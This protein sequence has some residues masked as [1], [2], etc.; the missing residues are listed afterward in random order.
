M[1]CEITKEAI[2]ELLLDH[3]KKI[4]QNTIAACLDTNNGVDYYVRVK[5]L[6]KIG[7]VTMDVFVDVS[8]KEAFR[9]LFI[10]YDYEFRS[11]KVGRGMKTVRVIVSKIDTRTEERTQK[12]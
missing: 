8:L 6:E 9:D 7:N 12:K 4:N 2:E 10:A 5:S 11:Y 3:Y 1:E